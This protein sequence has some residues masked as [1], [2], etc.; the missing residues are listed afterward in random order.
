MAALDETQYDFKENDERQESMDDIDS[1]ERRLQSGNP[2]SQVA[3]AAPVR[4]PQVAR[5][6]AAVGRTQ[7]KDFVKRAVKPS[8][9]GNDDEDDVEGD[10]MAVS[11]L[12][13]FDRQQGLDE[14]D[15]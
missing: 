3:K 8:R 1:F 9:A 7:G 6:K 4:K 12:D 15:D 13:K 14:D 5:P 10:R 11:D 2:S